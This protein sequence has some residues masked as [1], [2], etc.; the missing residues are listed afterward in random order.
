MD[1]INS[2]YRPKRK[3]KDFMNP[4]YFSH[5]RRNKIFNKTN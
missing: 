1:S 2:S 3:N 5:I 4:A